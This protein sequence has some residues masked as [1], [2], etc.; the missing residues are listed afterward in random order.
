[1]SSFEFCVA[2]C[3]ATHREQLF[4][5]VI[6]GMSEPN[7]SLPSKHFYDERG[8]Q[9]FDQ[10]CDLEE[11]Y[12]T[13]TETEIMHRSG[14]EMADRIGRDAR[15]VE[16][17]SGS[18]VKTRILLDALE[19]VSDYV[20]VDISGDHLHQVASKLAKDYPAVTISP[21]VADFTQPFTLPD[22]DNPFDRTCIYFPG[23]TI[24]NFT[25]EQAVELLGKMRTV[26]GERCGLLIG[27]D[28]QKDLNVLKA[29]YNDSDG[30][31]AEFNLNLLRRLNRELSSNFDLEN[32]EHR[33][34]Y[35]QAQDRIEMR[36]QSLCSQTV[37]LG[38]YR[39]DFQ[40][41]EEILT[42]YSHK[43]TIESFSELASRVGWNLECSWTDPRNYFAVMYFED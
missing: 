13:R 1:M 18:S 25:Q 37:S 26:A 40:A 38:D 17:G 24:G 16:Y 4:N 11:Y 20:P 21:V 10:I 32:F 28:L 31:T 41:G 33:A 5:D 35:D 27:V 42:E 34:I 39:F 23:S 30:V 9:L 3:R 22:C 19:A 36:L 7:R 29:A 14:N 8:S 6:M 12:L 2:E 43:Y 15:L